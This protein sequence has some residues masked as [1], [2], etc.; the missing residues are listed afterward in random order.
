MYNVIGLVV[1]A[2]QRFIY[3]ALYN[4]LLWPAGIMSLCVAYPISLCCGKPAK[5]ISLFADRNLHWFASV[6]RRQRQKRKARSQTLRPGEIM[7]K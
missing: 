7:M 3:S 5:R 4:V 2:V 1:A 6:T